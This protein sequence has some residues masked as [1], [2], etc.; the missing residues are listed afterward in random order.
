MK[1]KKRR[2]ND[3][4]DDMKQ[5]KIKWLILFTLRSE[6]RQKKNNWIKN[7]EKEAT[8]LCLSGQ[9]KNAR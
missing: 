5:F 2:K 3:D 9:H 8:V 6:V 4:D 1:K 7:R